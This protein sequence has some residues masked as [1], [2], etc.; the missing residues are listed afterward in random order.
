MFEHTHD[1]IQNVEKPASDVTLVSHCYRKQLDGV[2]TIRSLVSKMD[3]LSWLTTASHLDALIRT[4][5]G[6]MAS[7]AE[8]QPGDGMRTEWTCR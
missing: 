1:L 6:C 8:T 4:L 7:V 5:I 3:S 2:M